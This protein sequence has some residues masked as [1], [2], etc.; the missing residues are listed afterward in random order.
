MTCPYVKYN[1]FEKNTSGNLI[2]PPL[3]KN[4]QKIS[5]SEISYFFCLEKKKQPTKLHMVTSIQSQLT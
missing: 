4:P 3:K 2:D 5:F 1:I